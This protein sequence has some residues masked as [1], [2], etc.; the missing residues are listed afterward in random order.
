MNTIVLYVS[1]GG[2]HK[3]LELLKESV[4]RTLVDRCKWK[5]RKG[6]AKTKESAEKTM[7]MA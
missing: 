1:N 4:Y 5:G 2:K 3:I 6:M 7:W